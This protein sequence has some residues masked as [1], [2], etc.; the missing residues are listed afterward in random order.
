MICGAENV[1][2]ISSRTLFLLSEIGRGELEMYVCL[3]WFSRWN[4]LTSRVTLV[5]K[6]ELF[7]CDGSCQQHTRSTSN[8]LGY[9]WT[10]FIAETETDEPPHGY[11]LVR[12][13]TFIPG[14]I[15]VNVPYTPNLLY[16]A[17]RHVAS[18]E[19]A[20]MVWYL[21][22]YII[23]AKSLLLRCLVQNCSW[24]NTNF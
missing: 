17:G 6:C 9:R 20:L 23:N 4:N 5:Y 15:F 12:L 16:Q 21:Q 8:T 7:V 18:I 2:I 1:T 10:F 14:E 22:D 11:H 19:K 3:K 13:M 24:R